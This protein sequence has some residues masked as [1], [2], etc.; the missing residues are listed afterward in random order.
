MLQ[1]LYPPAAR[2]VC[3]FAL[4]SS[5]AGCSGS[6]SAQM[7][8]RAK[9]TLQEAGEA[10]VADAKK[11]LVQQARS[12]GGELLAVATDTALQGLT[13]DTPAAAAPATAQSANTRL[14]AA[15]DA[16]RA[17]QA[18]PS[19]MPGWSLE[20]HALECTA[21]VP[22]REIAELA[23]SILAQRFSFE[24]ASAKLCE[25]HARR[26][27]AEQDIRLERAAKQ[28]SGIMD[29]QRMHGAGRA[30]AEMDVAIKRLGKAIETQYGPTAIQ[31][32]GGMHAV[33]GCLA[34]ASSCR[35]EAED[36]KGA[37]PIVE[38]WLAGTA[39]TLRAQQLKASLGASYATL[40]RARAEAA[41]ALIKP[42]PT[43]I[44][45]FATE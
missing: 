44:N 16:T 14:G 4:L 34:G 2:A 37:W 29:E 10:V 5:V 12:A 31:C 43:Q 23:H 36:V 28:Y 39:T 22:E 3:A 20:D 18:R 7:K 24:V 38:S 40:A 30:M 41:G 45:P 33:A 8:A 27:A 19:D 26:S 15:A 1:A 17:S 13:A 6:L 21:S 9:A 25:Y 42:S 11:Q 35:S 32:V